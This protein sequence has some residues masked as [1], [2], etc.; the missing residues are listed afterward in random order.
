LN[1]ALGKSIS[2]WQSLYEKEQMLDKKRPVE[3]V[4][5]VPNACTSY[6]QLYPQCRYLENKKISALNGLQRA[7]F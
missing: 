7:D 3:N 4:L 2:A 6:P 1:Q 5:T